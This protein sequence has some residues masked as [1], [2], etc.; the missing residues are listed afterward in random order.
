MGGVRFVVY[1]LFDTAMS[2]SE[3]AVC[4]LVGYR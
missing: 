2:D 3:E 4:W 1:L